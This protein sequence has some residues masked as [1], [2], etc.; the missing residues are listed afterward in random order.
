MMKR[1][2][3]CFACLAVLASHHP[4][5]AQDSTKLFFFGH[6][7]IDHRPPRIPTPSDET[8]VPHWLFL[9]AQ[10]A[11]EPLGAG[12]QYGLLPQHANLPP[13]SQWG[14]DIVPGVWE[15]DL[16]PFSDA[17]IDMAII[18]ASNFAQWQ[19]PDLEYPSIPGVT[20]ISATE[21]I[22]D[23]LVGQEPGIR[24]YIYENWP[25][26]GGF[27]NVDFPPS[28]TEWAN[29]NQ[30]LNEAFHDWWIDYHDALVES[31]VDF[32]IKMI[33]VGPI[34]STILSTPTFDSIPIDSLY[35]DDAPHGQSTIYFLA[36]MV[37]YAAIFEERPPL[38]YVVPSIVHSTVRNRYS[39]LCEI[40]WT[41]LN[42]FDFENGESRVFFDISTRT[43]LT[44]EKQLTIFPN[45][46]GN[47]LILEIND[48]KHVHLIDT[49]G[50][51]WPVELNDHRIDVG[52]VPRGTYFLQVIDNLGQTRTK[53]LVLK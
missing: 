40:I 29:Y 17:D 28:P 47:Q 5:M 33:P 30:Y 12:G 49:K 22:V 18:T 13:I 3:Y 36:A 34:I 8:T 42:K 50:Q 43:D 48:I 46:A 15:S 51:S 16:E 53:K 11:G 20:P 52:S 7:L 44:G 6:S 19:G 32:E 39:D 14:Y 37:T 23:W 10:Q 25:D 2:V 21:E 31:R 26:M 4:L 27:L 24:L 45:P 41:E 9:L 35:E 1:I 38:D